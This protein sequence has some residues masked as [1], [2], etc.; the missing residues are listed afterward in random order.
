MTSFDDL[1]N[2]IGNDDDDQMPAA[3]I[4]S[5]APPPRASE[6]RVL[7]MNAGERAVLSVLLFVASLVLGA[8]ILIVTGR[9]VL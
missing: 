5:S 6:G 1:R 7:G 8:G 4:L 2:S 3:R 9:I